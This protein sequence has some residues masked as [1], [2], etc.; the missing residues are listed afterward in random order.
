MPI[1]SE[2]H[3][4]PNNTVLVINYTDDV[5]LSDIKKADGII[6]KFMQVLQ[7]RPVIILNL[8][9]AKECSDQLFRTMIEHAMNASMSTGVKSRLMMASSQRDLDKI[10][11]NLKNNADEITFRPTIPHLHSEVAFIEMMQK[12]RAL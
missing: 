12:T 9:N 6:Q 4:C 1:N 5:S 7:R 10:F 11:N 2:E 3:N 8:S